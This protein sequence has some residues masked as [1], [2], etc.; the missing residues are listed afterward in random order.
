VNYDVPYGKPIVQVAPRVARIPS[1]LRPAPMKG[2][3][4]PGPNPGDWNVDT[5]PIATYLMTWVTTAQAVQNLHALWKL[6][7]QPKWSECQCTQTCIS[8]GFVRAEVHSLKGGGAADVSGLEGK[9]ADALKKALSLIPKL[10]NG[11]SGHCGKMEGADCA[12]RCGLESIEDEYRV[13]ISGQVRLPGGGVATYLGFIYLRGTHII[14]LYKGLPLAP[15]I[16]VDPDLPPY[17]ARPHGGG[18]GRGPVTPSGFATVFSVEPRVPDRGEG[19]RHVQ[20]GTA[21]R[22]F[23]SV[24]AARVLDCEC[25]SSNGGCEC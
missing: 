14:I 15:G 13:P 18:G 8:V 1:A 16:P 3:R 2:P 10:K 7:K 9:I 23:G 20:E 12:A 4:A 17:E 11:D 24:T 19:W 25:D 6:V 22:P 21:L 5:S